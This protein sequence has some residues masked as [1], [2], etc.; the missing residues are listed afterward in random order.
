MLHFEVE[1][2]VAYELSSRLHY[3]ATAGKFPVS[4][5]PPSYSLPQFPPKYTHTNSIEN[6]ALIFDHNFEKKTQGKEC[7]SEHRNTFQGRSSSSIDT[8]TSTVCCYQ[9]Q[10]TKTAANSKVTLVFYKLCFVIEALARIEF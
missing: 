8:V 5:P 7:S 6:F 2:E 1:L 9:Q 4:H 10:K 3:L